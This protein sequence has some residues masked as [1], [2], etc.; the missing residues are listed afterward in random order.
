M[1]WLGFGFFVPSM[2]KYI[3]LVLLLS[4]FFKFYTRTF[5]F[6]YCRWIL[7]VARQGRQ[8]T[9]VVYLMIGI[10]QLYPWQCLLLL[11]CLM[12]WIISVRINHFCE[13][14]VWFQ[15]YWIFSAFC[16]INL[17]NCLEC[18][19]CSLMVVRCM[20]FSFDILSLDFTTITRFSH[21]D[22][23]WERGWNCI[24]SNFNFVS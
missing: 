24:P 15:S 13:Y 19:A 8:I 21:L 9:H 10:H 20:R 22:C 16:R 17:L 4:M 7:T 3:S 14:S 11:R 12:L 5:I 6:I 2:D 1:Q 23:I 18:F